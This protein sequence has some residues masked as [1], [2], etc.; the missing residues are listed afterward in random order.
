MKESEKFVFIFCICKT[1]FMCICVPTPLRQMSS[2]ESEKMTIIFLRWSSYTIQWSPP[3]FLSCYL[4][5]NCPICLGTTRTSV[6]LSFSFRHFLCLLHTPGFP[7]RYFDEGEV[8]PGSVQLLPAGDPPPP[9]EDLHVVQE[10]LASPAQPLPARHQQ[11]PLGD[12]HYVAPPAPVERRQAQPLPSLTVEE[13]H[14]GHVLVASPTSSRHYQ[15]GPTVD[16]SLGM[17]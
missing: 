4:L 15:A 2:T 14:R 9:V 7:L 3:V 1:S 6:S 16:F 5:S 10:L 13:L 12:R 11:L 17:F 8:W